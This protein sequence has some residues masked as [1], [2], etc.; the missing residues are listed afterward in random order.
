M[1]FAFKNAKQL[2]E[3]VLECA[4]FHGQRPA[5]P[6]VWV[7][8]SKDTPLVVVLGENAS[9][10]SFFRRVATEVV[11]TNKIEAI[12]ISMEGRKSMGVMGVFVYGSEE[13]EAT[14]VNSIRT[15]ITGIS[16]CKGR[17]TPHV[18]VWDEPDLGCSEDAA[19]SVGAALA[20]FAREPGIHTKAMVVIT[21]RKALVE[22]L[23]ALTPA[24]HYLFLG[25]V[26]GP[27]TLA[28]WLVRPPVVRPLEEIQKAGHRRFM[29]IQSILD[30][31]E[32]NRKRSR[33]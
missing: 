22:R 29:A 18:V 24:P 23:A 21:H 32:K 5:I 3:R 13:W 7:P 25:S 28:A 14:G 2:V 16:T 12:S 1:S 26:N 11:R 15:V 4:Y 20:A 30:K 9:G 8:G 33:R 17:A 27:P 19:A 10:K 31:L 6:Y